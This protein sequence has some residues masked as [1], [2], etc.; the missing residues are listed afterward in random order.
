M[1]LMIMRFW[2]RR[3][4]SG[5]RL[6]RRVLADLP[7]ILRVLV[8]EVKRHGPWVASQY[9][10]DHIVRLSTGAPS[11]HFSR[12]TS[13]MHV[14]GQYTG[15]GW[16][17][18]QK[19]G[20]TAVVNMRDEFDDAEAGIA[21]ENYL[22]LPTVDDTPPTIAQLSQG[23]RFIHKQIDEG[24][25]VYVHCMLGVGRSVTLVAAYLVSTGMTPTAAWRALRRRRPF[26]QPTLGQQA[27]LVEFAAQSPN[28]W[29]NYD[30]DPEIPEQ[31]MEE[32]STEPVMRE[33][34]G[35]LAL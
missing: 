3:L 31:E 32:L 17:R 16:R 21:P 27:R 20:I 6:T 7:Q 22:F 34:D 12:I 28:M 1:I 5:A 11:K 15:S 33:P 26:I 2:Y 19:R 29:M 9:T 18:L 25:Q 13:H 10:L 30:F 35:T 14:G 8:I 4:R 23:V 24:G